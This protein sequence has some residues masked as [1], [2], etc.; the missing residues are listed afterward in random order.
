MNGKSHRAIGIIAT[1]GLAACAF[2]SMILSG[3][4]VFPAVGLAVADAGAKLA[5]A[6]MENSAYGKKY[7]M[8]SKIFTH[9]GM[10][11]TGIVLLLMVAII[12]G[13]TA[14]AKMDR[15]IWIE[16]LL[17]MFVLTGGL[18]ASMKS[19]LTTNLTIVIMELFVLAFLTTYNE[20][21][22]NSILCSLV[23][24]FFFSYASH[25]FA[26]MHNRKGIPLAFPLCRRRLYVM[27]ITTGTWEEYLF[28][29]LMLLAVF[30]Q[31]ICTKFGIGLL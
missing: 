15:G 5:D 17:I 28:I 22:I 31:I 4:T 2:P 24:G 12:K 25:L 20:A 18:N 11:H 19:R 21:L 30:G 14:L 27:A 7:P 23:F 29:G 10:T 26:D 1:V 6:D 13:C 16:D 8:L 3:V 9:R